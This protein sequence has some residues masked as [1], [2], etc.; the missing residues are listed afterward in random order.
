VRERVLF[1]LVL[2]L[3]SCG[4]EPP[5]V[6]DGHGSGEFVRVSGEGSGSGD[7]AAAELPA[8]AAAEAEGSVEAPRP[9]LTIVPKPV[10]VASAA[11]PIGTQGGAIVAGAMTV[12]VPPNA[13]AA[14]IVLSAEVLAS[15]EELERD[16]PQQT[17]LGAYRAGPWNP[18]YN[19]AVDVEIP[20]A[21]SVPPGTELELLGW[22]PAMRAF[23]VIGRE[24]ADATGTK[25]LFHVRQLGDM[26]VRA[27][28]IQAAE[29]VSD[30]MGTSLRLEQ[31][32]PGPSE[33]N[34]T[35]LTP[36]EGR[37][38][39]ELA[40]SV[41]TDARL[42]PIVERVE[43][44]NEE[45]VD[46]TATRRNELD[47]RDED[48]LLDPNAAASLEVLGHLV[49]REWIDPLSGRPAYRVR[50]TE[51]YDALIEHSQ[52]STH[53]QGRA[54]DLT[55]SPVPAA[56]GDDRRELYGR[57]SRLAV[58][59]GFDYV[60][61]E[62]MAHVHV[63]VVPSRI[64]AVV[65]GADGTYRIATAR[66]TR[67]G[68]WSIAVNALAPV[69]GEVGAL[70]WDDAGFRIGVGEGES[71]RWFSV[72]PDGLLAPSA[73]ESRGESLSA[74]WARRIVTQ[75]GRGW[76]TYARAVV[77][78]GSLNADG[79]PVHVEY[80]AAFGPDGERVVAAAFRSHPRSDE[81][82]T[83]YLR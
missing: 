52:Q 63:S 60:L 44:K 41:L 79:R 15:P 48:Y 67:L 75:D 47:H 29:A 59:A 19:R 24:P 27:A 65:R 42:T 28:P 33:D 37:V 36:P 17:L 62:N 49:E 18:P 20:L 73:G 76:L 57:L 43:F 53:Y 31:A 32:W 25:A 30:C 66:L 4:A 14:P 70:V 3:A 51:S 58:C 71:E 55:L 38:A 40:F 1:A 77:P 7:G 46:S 80:P 21:F 8:V 54:V 10:E 81:A 6:V 2:L 64:A 61:F 50:V 39:R 34:V 16:L 9:P 11:A 23:I 45:I 83:R 13:I 82:R 35:G 74:D 69:A 78:I 68:D 5:A 26:V 22:Q 72:A 56:N 12:N